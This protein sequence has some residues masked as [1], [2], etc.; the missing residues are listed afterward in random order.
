MPSDKETAA[1]LGLLFLHL[2]S[3]K[4]ERDDVG[5]PS[6]PS[7]LSLHLNTAFL[8]PNK[9]IFRYTRLFLCLNKGDLIPQV[10]KQIR[11]TVEREPGNKGQ[12]MREEACEE[13]RERREAPREL[14][15]KARAGQAEQAGRGIAASTGLFHSVVSFSFCG[16]I[17]L[18]IC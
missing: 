16:V 15:T 6:Q 17:C 11:E 10:S 1:S 2:W 8:I 13:E 3:D 14:S 4:L 18:G 12:Q 5:G 9:C 7:I